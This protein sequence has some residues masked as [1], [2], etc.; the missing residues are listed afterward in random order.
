MVNLMTGL[1]GRGASGACLLI[2]KGNPKEKGTYIPLQGEKLLVGR[3]NSSFIPEICLDNFLI[4]RKHCCLEKCNGE[5]IIS[6]LGSKH[7][8]TVNGK[9]IGIN[10]KIV[11]KHGDKI[12]LASG[13]AVFRVIIAGEYEQT[14]EFEKTQPTNTFSQS[15][16]DIDLQRMKL[17]V[18][19]KAVSLSGKEWK[20]LEILY[21]RHN[22]FVSYDEIREHVWPERYAAVNNLPDVGVDEL[23]MLVYRLR[24]KLGSHRNMLRTL[25]G[26]GCIFEL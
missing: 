26:Q 24:R 9:P 22:N 10:T 21:N 11:L 23:N 12:G 25:R 14:L 20:L 2:E 3:P 19:K 5:W 4:S 6:D 1:K 15:P 7:G 13:V 17:T 8:T 18:D 16:L